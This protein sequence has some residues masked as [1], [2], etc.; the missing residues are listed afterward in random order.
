M[1]LKPEAN[2]EDCEPHPSIRRTDSIA[3]LSLCGIRASS[4]SN[5]FVLIPKCDFPPSHPPLCSPHREPLKNYVRT[6]GVCPKADIVREVAWI[7]YNGPVPDADRGVHIPVKYADVLYGRPIVTQVHHRNQ[8]DAMHAVAWRVSVSHEYPQ[9]GRK[10]ENAQKAAASLSMEEVVLFN[11]IAAVSPRLFLHWQYFLKH[12]C[13][14]MP[15]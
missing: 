3:A 7:Y 6:E 12:S 4:F 8:R 10:R 11:E 14:Q 9:F 1:P 13:I 15:F 5:Q 2:L